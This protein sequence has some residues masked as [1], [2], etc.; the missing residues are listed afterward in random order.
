MIEVQSSGNKKELFI[1]GK[2]LLVSVEDTLF[3]ENPGHIDVISVEKDSSNRLLS[4]KPVEVPIPISFHIIDYFEVKGF[5]SRIL[6]DYKPGDSDW[7]LDIALHPK[8]GEWKSPYSYSEFIS[9][10]L[11]KADEIDNGRWTKSLLD[12]ETPYTSPFQPTLH[13][14]LT[15]LDVETPFSFYLPDEIESISTLYSEAVTE[16][17]LI[18]RTETLLAVFQF[19]NSIRVACGQYLLYFATFLNDLGITAQPSVSEDAGK[20]LFSVI[21]AEGNEALGLIREALA[22]YLSLP[23]G[24]IEYDSSIAGMRLQQQIDSLQHAQRFAAREI[25]M[26]Q[27]VIESQDKIIDQKDGIILQKDDLIAQQKSVIEKITNE[28]ILVDSLE[29]REQLFEGLEIGKSEFLVKNIGVHL[30]PATFLKTIGRKLIGKDEPTESI[31]NPRA[32]DNQDEN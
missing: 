18:T 13:C 30:N 1:N 2:R 32:E 26:A 8:L 3:S 29:N 12:L 15:V 7:A 27:R 24:P 21:P 6:I 17:S 11:K 5:E 16:L 25:Q 22:V 4:E 9:A 10:F 28:A 19:P 23:A 31:F 20:V 14:R